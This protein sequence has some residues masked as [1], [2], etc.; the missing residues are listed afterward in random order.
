MA[1]DSRTDRRTIKAKKSERLGDRVRRC[2]S[3]GASRLY[4]CCSR[5]LLI[6]FPSIISSSSSTYTMRL[7]VLRCRVLPTFRLSA[8]CTHTHTHTHM[9]WRHPQLKQFADI[10][11]RFWLQ[12]RSKF[13]Y[14]AQFSAWLLTSLFHDGA[15]RHFAEH[16][17]KPSPWRRYC[18]LCLRY[19]CCELQRLLT[20]NRAVTQSPHKSLVAIIISQC[21]N[22]G[23]HWHCSWWQRVIATFAAERCLSFQR[24]ARLLIVQRLQSVQQ[25]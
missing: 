3:M 24:W 25:L 21:D 1:G 22:I 5:L 19:T 15:K 18:T 20:S 2:V 4:W 10:V 8:L 14:V 16:S 11:N 9:Q 12:R 6:C 23:T 17:P 7:G 13:E